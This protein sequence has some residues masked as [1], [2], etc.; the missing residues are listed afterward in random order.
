MTDSHSPNDRRYIGRK[1]EA[2]LYGGG[3]IMLWECFDNG[4]KFSEK[5]E[6]RCTTFWSLKSGLKSILPITY[7]ICE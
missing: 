5:L 4:A 1:E 2:C 3:T 7:E 6:E